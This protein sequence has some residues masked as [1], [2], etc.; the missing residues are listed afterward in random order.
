MTLAVYTICSRSMARIK[1]HGSEYRR[2]VH[3]TGPAPPATSSRGVAP[4]ATSSRG[5]APR[6]PRCVLKAPLR[7]APVRLAA[8]PA[9]HYMIQPLVELYGD[10]MVV[11][12]V[13]WYGTRPQASTNFEHPSGLLHKQPTI[14]WQGASRTS[15]I[16]QNSSG[17]PAFAS[18]KALAAAAS[19]PVISSAR[20]HLDGRT[21]DWARS[22]SLTVS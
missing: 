11:L 5:V 7:R 10:C 8:A 15:S 20:V 3:V 4:P 22:V 19:P 17:L 16:A 9:R 18:R 1:Q 6:W 21:I 13:S 12:K 2:Q 14:H